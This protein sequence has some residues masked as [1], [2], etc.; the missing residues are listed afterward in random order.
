MIIIEGPDGSGKS[1][2]VRELSQRLA[3]PVAGK[4]VDSETNAMFDLKQWV[5]NNLADGF[6]R[7]IFD[8]HRLISEPIYGTVLPWRKDT[9]LDFW[10]S[11]AWLYKSMHHFANI[12]PVVIV[13][14]PPYEVVMENILND[15]QNARVRTDMWAIYRGYQ[16]VIARGEA[17]QVYDYTTATE[18][19]LQRL[20]SFILHAMNRRSRG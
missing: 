11:D 12:K 1:T 16:M 2:L 14:L 9:H 18:Q 3:L 6:M 4:V 15:P 7:M 19:T 13:C 8:R 5:D 17:D 20:E 10:G